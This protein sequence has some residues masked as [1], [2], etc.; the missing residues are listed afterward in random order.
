MLCGVEESIREY[1]IF[2]DRS[3]SRLAT[4]VEASLEK[5]VALIDRRH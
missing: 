3:D 4:L 1:A 2:F 5:L